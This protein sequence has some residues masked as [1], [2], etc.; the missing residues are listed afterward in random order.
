MF[1]KQDPFLSSG[2]RGERTLISWV[3]QKELPLYSSNVLRTMG[4]GRHNILKISVVSSPQKF[5]QQMYW[6]FL[7]RGN[8][9][10]EQSIACNGILFVQFSW[11][12]ISYCLQWCCPQLTQG[13]GG[14]ANKRRRR[15]TNCRKS[16][17]KKAQNHKS[18][19]VY[20]SQHFAYFS[21]FLGILSILLVLV[22]IYCWWIF[23]SWTNNMYLFLILLNE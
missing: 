20:F 15:R 23:R 14:R 16:V 4:N 21:K 1:R 10:H 3:H 17:V 5:A 18:G 7:C 12:S 2:V 13:I 19:M 6:Y 9:N 22:F 11:Q 8:T